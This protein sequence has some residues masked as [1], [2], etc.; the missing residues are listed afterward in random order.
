MM[1]SKDLRL[2]SLLI[3]SLCAIIFLWGQKKNI[4]K[5]STKWLE[6]FVCLDGITPHEVAYKLTMGA[7]EVEEIQKIGPNLKGPIVV[8]KILDIQK[9]PNADKL[10]VCK[11][12]TDGKNVLQIVCGAK[13]IKAGQLVPVSLPGSKVI[14][15]QDG[16][17][18]LIKNTKIREID[19]S[20][21]LCSPGELG[22]TREDPNGI[23]IL[24]E[25]SEN[26]KLGLGLGLGEDVINYLSLNQD[27]V[28]EV[29]SRSNRGDAL[30]V[31]GLSKEISALTLKKLK[32]INFKTPVFDNSVESFL[33]KIENL[34]DTYVFYTATIENIKVAP[35][36]QWLIRLLESVGIRSINNVVDIT[37]YINFAFGQ[38]LHAYDKA[39]LRGK[40]G[41]SG[42]KGE[43]LTSRLARKGEKIQTLDGKLVELKEGVLVIAD[44][45]NPVAIAGI[46]GGKNS[47]VTENTKDIVFEAAVFNPARVRRGSR[48]VGLSS[49]ASKRFERGVDTNFTYNALLKAIE[50]VCDL[51]PTKTKTGKIQQCGKPQDNET[52]IILPLMEVKRVLGITLKPNETANF[53]K[54]LGFSPKILGKEKIEVKVPSARQGD[55]TRPIDLIEEVA[56]LYGYDQIP[57]LP[58]PA[59]VAANVTYNGGKI[60]KIKRHFLGC[61]FSETCLSSLIGEQLLSYSEFP[62]DKSRAISM[63]NPLSN[64]HYV[65][66]QWILPGLLEA[67]KLNQSHQTLPVRFFE[68]GKVYFSHNKPTEKDSGVKETLR[69]S[70]II[71][72]THKNWLNAEGKSIHSLK[73]P[74]MLFFT[75]KGTLESLLSGTNYK[76]ERLQGTKEKFLHPNFSLKIILNNKEIG[77]FGC[78]HP[79]V[80]NTHEIT[81]PTVVFEIDLD[82]ILSETEKNKIFEKISSQP[83]VQR[84]ITIDLSKK[85]DASNVISEIIKIKSAYVID[86]CLISVYELDK[87]NRSLTYRLK[88]QDFEQTLTTK[89]IED[90]VIFIKKHLTACFQ[91]KFRV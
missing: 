49:E 25:T 13:N 76:F 36:P 89:Q 57:S 2:C 88:M 43:S 42:K 38:P 5:L 14:N 20:G 16:S 61:G 68:I 87:E 72:G 6:N 34:K 39:M 18:V 47:E 56:R 71:S 53:L 30:S 44:E 90:E 41:K 83:I 28:M 27:T 75:L 11:V 66:R 86:M 40:S 84:D 22:I 48:T 73:I 52:K 50:L 37:N 1:N 31:Y 29:A 59:T 62:F 46:M 79:T 3:F 8:G 51:S 23:L 64:E 4:M 12:T 74:D 67:L 81:N 24:S 54:S 35:S 45:E 21:M 78:L 55:V 58:P 91:A 32:E 77:L 63:M 19:S 17:E 7:F 33:P 85:Y 60:E 80:E 9:H 10:S 26:A 70:G 69:I 65:L 82:C 15:R